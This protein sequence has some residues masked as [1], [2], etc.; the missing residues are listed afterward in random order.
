MLV[1]SN[2]CHLAFLLMVTAGGQSATLNQ[3]ICN[4]FVGQYTLQI[5]M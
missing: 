5:D 4:T 3:H 2:E 1:V